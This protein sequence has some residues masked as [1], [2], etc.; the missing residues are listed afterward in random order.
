MGDDETTFLAF[1]GKR[2]G[3]L[4]AA[5]RRILGDEAEAEDIVQDTFTWMWAHRDAVSFRRLEAYALRAVQFNALKRRARRR[6]Q[7]PLESAAEP[8]APA[9][10]ESD[11]PDQI[12]PWALELALR[13]LPETQQVVLRLKYYVGLTFREIGARLA[14]SANTAASRCRYGLAV[15]RAKLMEGRTGSRAATVE[16]AGLDAAPP[17]GGL[18]Q[19]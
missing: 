4:I 5:A 6:R 8:E 2:R 3:E 15:L 16:G 13:E 12:D 14:I 10:L 11:A 19:Q 17:R 1:A 9:H 7:L 18:N